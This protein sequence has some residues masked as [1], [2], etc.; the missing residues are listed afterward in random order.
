MGADRHRLDPNE[1]SVVIHDHSDGLGREALAP[2]S[3]L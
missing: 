1:G 3:S 2:T